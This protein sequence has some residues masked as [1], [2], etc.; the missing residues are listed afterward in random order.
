[1][2][3]ASWWLLSHTC[4][5]YYSDSAGQG[6]CGLRIMRSV[7]TGRNPSLLLGTQNAPV[8]PFPF[9][10]DTS[11]SIFHNPHFEFPLYHS[12]CY[13]HRVRSGHWQLWVHSLMG[14]I[15]VLGWRDGCVVEMPWPSRE[16]VWVFILRTLCA[17]LK[18]RTDRGSELVSWVSATLWWFHIVI[19]IPS[20]GPDCL[21]LNLSFDAF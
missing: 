16:W 10:L 15:P 7:P 4:A 12:L 2:N 6:D 20:F 9:S 3:L 1:M 21:G 17:D 5:A 8:S 13:T 19:H 14:T 18:W 11:I